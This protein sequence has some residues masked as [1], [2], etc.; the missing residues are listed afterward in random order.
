VLDALVAEAR[1]R[2][3]LDLAAGLQVVASER[4]IATPIEPSR[5]LLL[6]P[7]ATLRAGD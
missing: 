1:L 5:P 7:L 3:G 2:W 6:V 4:L